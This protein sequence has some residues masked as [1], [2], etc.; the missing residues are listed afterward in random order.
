MIIRF[1]LL[2]TIFIFG[3]FKLQANTGTAKFY[4]ATDS[5]SIY[6]VN[7]LNKL[8]WK[9][10][11]PEEQ[12]KFG[13]NSNTTIWCKL[14]YN[15]SVAK[16]KLYWHFDNVHLDY[17]AIYKNQ[18]SLGILGDRTNQKSSFLR[19]HSF[20]LENNVE[21]DTITLIASV[22][23]LHT[24]I[25]FSMSVQDTQ[26]LLQKSN[27]QLAIAFTFV[28][29]AI[30][31]LAL[32]GFVYY[33]LK[34]KWHLYYL[35][36][37]TMGV[38]FV[39]VNLGILR[40]FIF[41]DFLYF[42]EVRIY[43]SCY[44]FLLMGIFL[45]ETIHFKENN[46]RLYRLFMG[47]QNTV[48]ALSILALLLLFS[49]SYELLTYTT[50]IIFTLFLVNIIV[51][52]CATWLAFRR[53]ERLA[54]Y[55]AIS[56]LPHILWGLSLILNIAGFE[57]YLNG[58]NWINWII[59]Y[60]MILF[61]WLLIKDYV[62]AIESNT[63]L[64]QEISHVEK[65]TNK[66]IESARLKE[67][68]QISD[69]LHDKISTDVART[70][71][72]L[73]SDELAKARDHISEL[74]KNIRNLSHTILPVELKHGALAQALQHHVSNLN[75]DRSTEFISFQSYDFPE[76][77]DKSLATSLYLTLLELLQNALKHAEAKHIQV[78]LYCYPSEYVFTV[79]DDGKGFS[80]EQQ[81][82][83]GLN[84]ISARIKDLGGEFSLSSTPDNG[85]NCMLIIPISNTQ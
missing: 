26:S 66:N 43:S 64:K 59:A 58:L 13:Y 23:K 3:C 12:I 63:L 37:T 42:S 60:E 71:Q 57:N 47:I 20:P 48:F 81:Y 78:E 16:E 82:G 24:T 1:K 15:S 35:I 85:V 75:G 54:K 50:S 9:A 76:H 70:M 65:T 36:Y 33:R 38:L 83:F 72:S 45:S 84:N 46:Y 29:T 41:Y 4:Y 7:E 6:K 44:W 53:S 28:G 79:S 68:R 39:L 34:R 32:T 18:K 73:D 67:R 69:L 77:I 25:E 30:I 27:L 49:G 17:I 56:F 55:V 31:F 74:G 51:F 80:T 61:G 52:I 21:E 8:S 62:L 40:Y 2:L 5:Q 10:V 11:K 19:G 14:I 22:K